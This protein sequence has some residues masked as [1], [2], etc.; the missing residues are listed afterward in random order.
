MGLVKSRWDVPSGTT[1][2]WVCISMF[3]KLVQPP[4]NVWLSFDVQSKSFSLV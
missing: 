3:L 1:Q 2:G 4:S